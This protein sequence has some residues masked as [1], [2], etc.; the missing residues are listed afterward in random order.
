[1]SYMYNNRL[2]KLSFPI[3]ITRFTHPMLLSHLCI[4][5]RKIHCYRS[6]HG[7][8]AAYFLICDGTHVRIKSMNSRRIRARPLR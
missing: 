4:L 1:M 5:F 6:E 8:F 3:V 2:V 7:L